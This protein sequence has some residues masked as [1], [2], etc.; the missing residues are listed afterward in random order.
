MNVRRGERPKHYVGLDVS[1]KEVSI[2]VVDADG[3]VAA[4]PQ[5]AK[6]TGAFNPNSGGGSQRPSLANHFATAEPHQGLP[7]QAS[8]SWVGRVPCDPGQMLCLLHGSDTARVE[9]R[10][11]AIIKPIGVGR[12]H[13]GFRGWFLARL[14]AEEHPCFRW[15]NDSDI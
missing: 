15:P 9:R 12:I 11:S 4:K 10:P 1:L 2:C 8:K 3:V 14:P 7:R 13:V 6:N 5:L